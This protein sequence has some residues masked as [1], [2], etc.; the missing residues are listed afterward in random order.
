MDV[1][2]ADRAE[3]PNY[4]GT[5]SFTCLPLGGGGSALAGIPAGA[6]PAPG[7]LSTRRVPAGIASFVLNL[8]ICAELTR[9]SARRSS[10]VDVALIIDQ[11][12]HAFRNAPPGPALLLASPAPKNPPSA[13]VLARLGVSGLAPQPRSSSTSPTTVTSPAASRRC[14]VGFAA[15]SGPSGDDY[16]DAPRNAA[17]T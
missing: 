11:L 16:D 13:S 14:S 1:K 9:Y 4:G 3:P 17:S 6:R 5:G 15:T 10:S 12:Y 8:R 7:G 2:S